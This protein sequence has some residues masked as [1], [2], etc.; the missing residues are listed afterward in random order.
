MAT[1]VL[2]YRIWCNTDSRWEYV[3]LEE[4]AAEPTKCPVD[5]SHSIDTNKTSIVD[6]IEEDTVTVR[7]ENTPTGGRYQACFHELTVPSGA[8]VTTTEIS[9]PHP[10]SLLSAE[11]TNREEFEGD[12]IRFTVAPDTTVGVLASGVASGAHVA[13][14]SDTV[15]DNIAI[16]FRANLLSA[17]GVADL[18]RVTDVDRNNKTITF[19][20]GCPQQFSHVWP[21][22]V[23]MSVDVVRES[24][25]AG[26]GRVQLGESKIGGSHIPANTVL[27]ARFTN[28][29]GQAKSLIFALEYLY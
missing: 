9:F 24:P 14:V 19:E 16:G 1:T 13:A 28:E 11:W 4:G 2:K 5:T 18:G 15:L 6:R 25:M 21:T 23:Q 3:L 10:I 8:G 17:S 7:E 29:N 20:T 26:Y 22:Y 12:K 27:Q